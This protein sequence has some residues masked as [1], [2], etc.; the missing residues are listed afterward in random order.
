M[1]LKIFK[2]FRRSK[3]MYF[4]PLRLINIVSCSTEFAKKIC[5]GSESLYAGSDIE[6]DPSRCSTAFPNALSER[7]QAL[8]YD[9]GPGILEM[10]FS[11]LESFL[12][13]LWDILSPAFL[14][15]L[16]GGGSTSSL[17]VLRLPY[18][19][20]S[21]CTC[22]AMVASSS[23]CLTAWISSWRSLLFV[24]EVLADEAR[25]SVTAETLLLPG[26]F[27]VTMIQIG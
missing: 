10:L 17:S 19:F 4:L 13:L 12:G 3:N 8:R 7:T 6:N 1:T 5:L 23:A 11:G 14:V 9:T 25:L 16:P 18:F 22:W 2:K 24:G 27:R 15:N 20:S 26:K 21:S